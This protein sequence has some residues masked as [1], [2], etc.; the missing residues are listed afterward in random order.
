MLNYRYDL[1]RLLDQLEVSGDIK[2]FLGDIFSFWMA[3]SGYPEIE[4]ALA[5]PRVTSASKIDWLE[6]VFAGMFHETFHQFLL[7]LAA[8]GDI[9]EFDLL[10]RRFLKRVATRQKIEFVEVVS[11]QPLTREQMVRIRN[12]M[13]ALTGKDIFV[14]NTLSGLLLGG[15]AIKY[16]GKTLDLSVR[17]DLETLGNDFVYALS[18]V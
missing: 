7:R 16:K 15:F 11:V 3:R 12:H 13:I 6:S 4:R 9:H 8:N 14:H 5:D 1:G 18:E 17:R 2:W 10:A